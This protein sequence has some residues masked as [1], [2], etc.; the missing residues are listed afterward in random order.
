MEIGAYRNCPLFLGN[1]DKVRNLGCVF[2]GK[3]KNY[4]SQL[5][6]FYF[7]GNGFGWVHW[8]FSL[9]NREIIMPSVNMMFYNGGV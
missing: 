3:D 5:M 2:N 1:M 7:D 4:L 8:Y 6:Y 9:V